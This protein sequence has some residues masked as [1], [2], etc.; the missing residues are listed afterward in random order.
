MADSYDIGGCRF[1]VGGIGRTDDDIVLLVR[2]FVVISED[3][4]GL[5]RIYAVAADLVLR[6]DDI[7]MLAVR[8]LILEAVDEVVLRRSPFCIGAIF[9]AHRVAHTGDLGHV[10]FVNGVAAA[11]DHDLSAAGRYCRLQILSH[12]CCILILNILL[13]LAQVEF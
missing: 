12:S 2:Q 11:H 4:V 9:T 13:H 8:Q 10:G 7:V 3:D 5:V 1:I 6:T